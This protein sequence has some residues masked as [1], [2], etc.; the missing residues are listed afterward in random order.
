MPC[1]LL[2][3]GSSLWQQE[4]GG[5]R[6]LCCSRD[7][8]LFSRGREEV[9]YWPGGCTI[10]FLLPAGKGFL[11]A[12]CAFLFWL[13]FETWSIVLLLKSCLDLIINSTEKLGITRS[14]VLLV[15][16]FVICALVW[17]RRLLTVCVEIPT[18]CSEQPAAV[19]LNT[20]LKT[21]PSGGIMLEAELIPARMSSRHS[22]HLKYYSP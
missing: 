17:V 4:G 3:W 19:P 2:Q 12:G 5:I 14:F 20:G 18:H 7:R 21:R 11:G 16:P 9:E 1:W 6:G 15:K 22:D 8:S 10:I 13:F